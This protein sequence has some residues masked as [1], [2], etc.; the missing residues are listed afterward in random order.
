MREIVSGINEG[1]LRYEPQTPHGPPELQWAQLEQF[2]HALHGAEP[3]QRATANSVNISSGFC[4][5]ILRTDIQKTLRTDVTFAIP[6]MLGCQRHISAVADK[7]LRFRMS[8]DTRLEVGT[9]T[10]GGPRP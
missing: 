3:V 5:S 4:C 9:G 10:R 7:A 6:C 2:L 1:A 8:Q